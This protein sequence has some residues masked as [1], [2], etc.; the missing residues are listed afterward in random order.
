ML[1]ICAFM[2][3]YKYKILELLLKLPP[4]QRKLVK[5]KLIT[6][7][8]ISRAQLNKIIKYKED[9]TSAISTDKLL[10]IANILEVPVSEIISPTVPKVRNAHEMSG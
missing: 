8:G 9:S 3:T 2:N 10:I 7:L 4:V 5:E 1:K 6:A